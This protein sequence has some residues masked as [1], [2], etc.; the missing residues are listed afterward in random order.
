MLIGDVMKITTKGKYGLMIM[1]YLAEEY[2][3]DRFVS[4]KEIAENEDI[5]IKYLEKVMLNFKNSDFFITSRGIDGGYKL[6]N[7]PCMY[8]IGE[9]IKYAEGSTDVIECINNDLCPKKNKCKTFPVWKELNDVIND[10]LY[11]KT[12]QDFIEGKKK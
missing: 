2:E 3:N 10:F 5:S 11:S 8:T 1:F 4:L 12:L 7:K 9:I 6:K